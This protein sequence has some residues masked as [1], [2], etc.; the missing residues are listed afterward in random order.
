MTARYLHP[1]NLRPELPYLELGLHGPLESCRKMNT[2]DGFPRSWRERHEGFITD[3]I[4]N[5]AFASSS[6]LS[7]MVRNFDFFLEFRHLKT[8]ETTE[9]TVSN[10][11]DVLFNVR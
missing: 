9:T 4:R 7:R 5:I 6:V 8:I 11:I 2:I 3:A 10:E 1:L